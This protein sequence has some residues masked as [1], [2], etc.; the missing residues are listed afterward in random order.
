MHAVPTYVFAVGLSD[1][2]LYVTLFDSGVG[3]GDVVC[4]T[5]TPV[6]DEEVIFLSIQSPPDIRLMWLL[7]VQGDVS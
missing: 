4:E 7:L 2:G 6:I 3:I 1:T 5:A